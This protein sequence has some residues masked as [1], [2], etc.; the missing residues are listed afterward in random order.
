MM[1]CN[2][3][4]LHA[5][6]GGT[7]SQFES[8]FDPSIDGDHDHPLQKDCSIAPLDDT[9]ESFDTAIRFKRAAE[10]VSQI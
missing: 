8:T 9:N 2:I 5:Y 3:I 7:G 4:Y 6:G 10:M 1:Y